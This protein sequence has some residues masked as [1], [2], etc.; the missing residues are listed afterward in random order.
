MQIK[1]PRDNAFCEVHTP[2]WSHKN[3]CPSTCESMH[4]PCIR[5]NAL[6]L[7]K[8]N[9]NS[10]SKNIMWSKWVDQV[11]GTIASLYQESYQLKGWGAH[12]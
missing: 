6:S 1:K 5:Q 8:H 3:A 11:D 7:A 9:A 12:F 2:T 10:T 4:Y